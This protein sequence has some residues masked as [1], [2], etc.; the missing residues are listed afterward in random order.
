[1]TKL[2]CRL[3]VGKRTQQN[4]LSNAKDKRQ[5]HHAAIFIMTK[6]QSMLQGIR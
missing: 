4:K 1:M 5:D 3:I 2:H 6:T